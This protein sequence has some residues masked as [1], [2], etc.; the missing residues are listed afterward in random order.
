MRAPDRS[1]LRTSTYWRDKADEAHAAAAQMSD[2]DGKRTME[3]I[4]EVY[5]KMAAAAETREKP[6]RVAAGP[7]MLSRPGFARGW[8]SAGLSAAPRTRP[9]PV[10]LT[11]LPCTSWISP[12]LAAAS[13]ILCAWSKVYRAATP[14]SEHTPLQQDRSVYRKAHDVGGLAGNRHVATDTTHPAGGRNR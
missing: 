12:A 7:M 2:R 8:G 10:R 6:S 4:A 11:E 13:A 3:Q 5:E 1:G 14:W 9:S